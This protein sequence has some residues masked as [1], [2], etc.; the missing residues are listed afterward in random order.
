M[1]RQTLKLLIYIA[2]A[3]LTI[4]CEGCDPKDV[5][6]DA[7]QTD[8]EQRMRAADSLFNGMQ[9]RDAYDL[10][11]Q[12]LDSK[13]VEAD[14]EKRLRVLSSLSNTSELS[15]HKDMENK[16]ND[17]YHRSAPG[18]EEILQINSNQTEYNCKIW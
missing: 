7:G 15:G 11:V 3:A 6:A 8:F 13:E 16:I 14:S 12:L 9:F 2:V 4:S 17:N 1:I 10:Y 18:G 5:A